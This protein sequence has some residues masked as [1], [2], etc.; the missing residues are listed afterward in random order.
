MPGI[1]CITLAAA[2]VYCPP[3][4]T[5]ISPTLE[6]LSKVAVPGLVLWIT[7]WIIVIGK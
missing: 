7:F 4:K 2:A 5:L 6:H 1:S 3:L